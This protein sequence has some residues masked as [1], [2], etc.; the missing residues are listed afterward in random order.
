MFFDKYQNKFIVK[1]IIKADTPLHIGAGQDSFNPVQVDNGVIVD[2]NGNP[3]IPGSS[4]KGVL[5]S[6]IE[7][8]VNSWTSLDDSLKACLIVN[9]PC[10]NKDEVDKIRKKFEKENDNKDLKIAQEIYSNM[11]DVCKVFGS[12][13]FA[14]KISIRD[15]TLKDEKANIQRRDGVAIDRE[16]GTAA[17]NKKYDYEQVAAGTEFDFYLSIDNLDEEHIDLFKLIIRSLTSGEL[18][19]GGKTTYGLG[20]IRLI[21]YEIY[22]ITNENLKQYLLNGLSDEMRWSH[23]W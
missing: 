15:C 21:D 5:R 14:A 17:D 8:A 6:Y 16:T 20:S 3:Y 7:T 18:Q 11:C 1:G 4:L 10:L 13:Y 19:I 2:H 22:K 12:H 9:E 23:V